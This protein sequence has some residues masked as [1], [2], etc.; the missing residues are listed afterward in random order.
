MCT[1]DVNAE[2]CEYCWSGS[3][4]RA[5]ALDV[6][7][8]GRLMENGR[9][10]ARIVKWL[11]EWEGLGDQ[12]YVNIHCG[13]VSVHSLELPFLNPPDVDVM[14]EFRMCVRVCDTQSSTETNAHPIPLPP[15]SLTPSRIRHLRMPRNVLPHIACDSFLFFGGV[16][17]KPP[18]FMSFDYSLEK[19]GSKRKRRFAW[20]VC[21]WLQLCAKHWKTF[22][23]MAFWCERWITDWKSGSDE[24][25]VALIANDV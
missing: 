13:Y 23:R 4:N 5:K 16:H 9:E 12:A 6:R 8:N 20:I 15:H 2:R 24:S 7:T 14:I 1:L 25:R 3:I 19:K 17:C 10:V 18:I 11:K 22:V 21:V